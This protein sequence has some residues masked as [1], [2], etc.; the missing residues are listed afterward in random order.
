MAIGVAIERYR[1]MLPVD[2]IRAG[3]MTPVHVAP[4][5]GE[6]IVLIVKVIHPVLVEKAVRVVHP[7]VWRGVMIDRAVFLCRDLRRGIGEGYE[8]PCLRRLYPREMYI[9]LRCA[10]MLQVEG[11][12]VIC[13]LPLSGKADVSNIQCLSAPFDGQGH[14][15]VRLTDGNDHIPA[16]PSV[17]V[18]QQKKQ[19]QPQKA[20]EQS[21]HFFRKLQLSRKS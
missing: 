8:L 19:G 2:H 4:D 12:A 18:K 16:A 1:L 15:V 20:L 3:R 17:T 10:E 21:R 6:R 13:L 5:A 9:A 11:H 14:L 7:S